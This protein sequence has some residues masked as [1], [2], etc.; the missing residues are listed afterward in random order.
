[1]YWSAGE[2]PLSN[3]QLAKLLTLYEQNYVLIRLLVPRLQEMPQGVY[4]SR[5]EHCLDLRLQVL[6]ISPYTTTVNLSYVFDGST[7]GHAAPDLQVRVYHDARSTEALSGLVHGHRL[8]TRTVRTL[9]GS[10]Q[11]NRF[12]YKWLRYC[13]HRG[14]IFQPDDGVLNTRTVPSAEKALK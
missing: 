8:T 7:R 2:K 13:R 5:V 4:W 1:M 3:S 14:H 10:W 6:E 11:L 12:L 9:E